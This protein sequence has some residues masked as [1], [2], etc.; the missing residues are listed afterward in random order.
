MPVVLRHKGFKYFFFSNEGNPREPLHIHVRKGERIAKIWIDP[1]ISVAE[2]FKVTS[3]EL[4]EIL[5][6]VQNQQDLIR[7]SWD[8]HFDS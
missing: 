3:K 7:R 5:A 6:V 4:K 2:S 8:E 1:S